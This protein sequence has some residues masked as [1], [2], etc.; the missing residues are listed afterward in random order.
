M[1]KRSDSQKPIKSLFS[2]HEY[3]AIFLIIVALLT[4]SFILFFTL[5]RVKITFEDARYAALATFA[6]IFLISLLLTFISGL[7]KKLT[8]EKPV[9]KILEATRSI[10]NGRLDTRIPTRKVPKEK[11]NEFDLII[12]NINLMAG[13]L[14]GTEILRN[15]FI[16]NVSHEI[17]TPLAAIQNY[18]VLL[19]DPELSPKKRQEYAKAANASCKRL[20]ALITN[21]LKLNK[22]ENQTIFPERKRFNLSEQLCSCMLDFETIWE[23]KNIEIDADIDQDI[24]MEGDEELLSLVWNNL[25]SN[26]LKFTD[27]G[28]RV[29]VSLKQEGE[30]I[31]AKVSDNGCGIDSESMKRI[32][33]KFYQ[34]D[35]SHAS[36]GNGLGLAL[37]H[38][39]VELSGGSIEVDSTPGVGS[40]FKVIL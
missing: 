28:G 15:D 35:T 24:Y 34:G 39:V 18:C 8:V 7:Q 33:E 5:T 17:K 2:F 23:K 27:E 14:S 26:A 36:A 31:I 40:V 10:A 13:E 38:K 22:L 9:K 4:S 6:N 30:R 25:L 3:V 11:F 21:I 1:Q 32:F 29:A 16:S 37:A 12:E 20:S 19:Q